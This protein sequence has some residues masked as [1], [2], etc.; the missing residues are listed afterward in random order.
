MAIEKRLRKLLQALPLAEV[1]GV[2]S[3]FSRYRYLLR[4]VHGMGLKESFVNQYL[5]GKVDVLVYPVRYGQDPYVKIGGE[6]SAT[7][8]IEKTVR[9]YANAIEA[10]ILPGECLG[11]D[12]LFEIPGHWDLDRELTIENDLYQ[13]VF[14]EAFP[15]GKE[16]FVELIHDAVRKYPYGVSKKIL[17]Y[18]S[19]VRY[20]ASDVSSLDDGIEK[21]IGKLGKY[22]RDIRI[23]A[24]SGT[25]EGLR[26]VKYDLCAQYRGKKAKEAEDVRHLF[27]SEFEVDYLRE[28]TRLLNV[29]DGEKD[30]ILSEQ[31]F[32]RASE[33]ENIKNTDDVGKAILSNYLEILR[34]NGESIEEL[35]RCLYEMYLASFL[36]TDTLEFGHMV[37]KTID[38]VRKAYR[39][40][41]KRPCPAASI[42]YRILCNQEGYILDLKKCVD[43]SIEE[44]IHQEI[45]RGIEQKLKECEARYL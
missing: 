22:V 26:G 39:C 9:E 27:E 5:K 17:L 19:N 11:E 38:A 7:D 14:I 21:T 35:A 10:L 3:D 40:K 6:Y 34:G 13:I 12:F 41:S 45:K 8:D 18:K 2:D 37:S 15:Y 29:G 43:E 32:R 4:L 30:G 36:D 42:E 33:F 20:G 16:S 23:F 31:S 28:S 24:E 44:Q 1:L 25:S